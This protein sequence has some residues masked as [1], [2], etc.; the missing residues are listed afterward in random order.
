MK[1]F[2]A[3][4]LAIGVHS[5]GKGCNEKRTQKDKSSCL[6]HSYDQGSLYSGNVNVTKSGK[7]CLMWA[8][9]KRAHA[10]VPKEMENGKTRMVPSNYCRNGGRGMKGEIPKRNRVNYFINIF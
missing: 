7:P 6:K 10:L 2:T 5:A 8:Q 9:P 3:C 4:F 1:F